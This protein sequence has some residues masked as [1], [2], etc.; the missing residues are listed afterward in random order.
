MRL[1]RAAE[2]LSLALL[3]VAGCDNK[4]TEG[5]KGE[6]PPSAT[7][8]TAPVGGFATCT[9]PAAGAKPAKPPSIA[10][11]IFTE[12]TPTMQGFTGGAGKAT[13]LRQVHGLIDV[14]VGEATSPGPKR[15]SL[16]A[17]WVCARYEETDKTK[18][19]AWTTSPAVL[20]N[21]KVSDYGAPPTYSAVTETSKLDEI[22][23]RKPVPEKVDPDHPAP[24]DWLDEA[25]LS[26]FVSSGI[27]PGPVSTSAAA[28]AKDACA[29]GPS[30]A[31]IARA[32]SDRAK[33][34]YGVWAV[35]ILLPYTGS[36]VADVPV[37][38][39]YLN[40]T[41]AHLEGIKK[42][43]AGEATP[44]AG[45]ELKADSQIPVF[46]RGASYSRFAY[47]GVR[48]LL[49]FAL[50]RNHEA[51]RTFVRSL[52][53]KLKADPALRTGKMA[54]E[55]VVGSIEL[56]P[57]AFAKY[58]LSPPE[59]APRGPGGQ[60][61]IDPTALA[62]FHLTNPGAS[63]NGSWADVS[64]GAQGKAWVLAKFSHAPPA[65]P[66]PSFVKQSVR[67]DGPSSNA[68]LPAKTSLAQRTGE[69]PVFRIFASCGP[70]TARPEP[71]AIEYLMQAKSELDEP[72]LGSAWFARASAPNAY[73]MPERAYGL[74]EIFTAVLRQAVTV[75][76]CSQKI[77]LNIK[78]GT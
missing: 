32:L 63:S 22:L 25:G 46:S 55:D 24:P 47:R 49:V 26:V 19:A 36:Y 7:S 17:K 39:K 33:E 62:E 59:M 78:R 11:R 56:A 40:A 74:R 16:G 58:S 69:E 44:F 64:C 29:S 10:G 12:I 38:A 73:E 2:C 41:K 72:A 42:V 6:A 20:C 70:L 8:S 35:T 54:Y 66:V 23:V 45:V 67:L 5:G 34:G 65:I 76:Y 13:S 52:T 68:T 1:S 3:L 37:D 21:E 50:S 28:T 75:E 4:A 14:A 48:P 15:C 53:D 9:G 27:E 30:P 60:G 61:D 71:W 77:R 57:L 31:C 51:G 43:A 18:C